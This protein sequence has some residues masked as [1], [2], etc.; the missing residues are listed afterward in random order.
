LVT[1][2][3]LNTYFDDFVDRTDRVA[4]FVAMGLSE[5]T[6]VAIVDAPRRPGERTREVRKR[7]RCAPTAD[8]DTVAPDPPAKAAAAA[9]ASGV[10]HGV[11]EGAAQR[12]VMCGYCGCGTLPECWKPKVDDEFTCDDCYGSNATLGA[13]CVEMLCDSHARVISVAAPAGHPATIEARIVDAIEQWDRLRTVH[14]AK[15][16]LV[17]AGRVQLQID[18]QWATKTPSQR[19]ES[20]T[21]RVGGNMVQLTAARS[22][23]DEM[24][25]GAFHLFDLHKEAIGSMY[26]KLFPGH[27]IGEL[28]FYGIEY[29]HV[30]GP[31]EKQF[32]HNKRVRDGYMQLAVFLA[33]APQATV[34]VRWR[35]GLE[36]A[37]RYVWS[38]R[39]DVLGNDGLTEDAFEAELSLDGDLAAVAAATTRAE[40][41]QVGERLM[42]PHAIRAGHLQAFSVNVNHYGG[43]VEAGKPRTLLV[44]LVNRG[45]DGNTKDLE[46][47]Q[48]HGGL[49]PGHLGLFATTYASRRL[50]EQLGTEFLR[51]QGPDS[52]GVFSASVWRSM[53]NP[54]FQPATARAPLAA[55]RGQS[56]P[57]E[58][59]APL[60][61]STRRSVARIGGSRNAA[62]VE[63]TWVQQHSRAMVH[64]SSLSNPALAAV[65]IDKGLRYS[66]E[67]GEEKQ[68]HF[69]GA[70]AAERGKVT[71]G[72]LTIVC[73]DTLERVLIKKGQVVEI[74]RGL[75]CVLKNE[76]ETVMNKTYAVFDKYGEQSMEYD[77]DAEELLADL[78]CDGCNIDVWWESFKVGTGDDARDYCAA[79]LADEKTCPTDA[80]AVA[81]RHVFDVEAATT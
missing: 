35:P 54:K 75:R 8:S 29:V 13:K 47:K 38:L 27:A 41:E 12:L 74:R 48:E 21:K 39:H 43:E 3:Q 28:R 42:Y 16:H 33:D 4:T 60:A 73:E 5:T 6:A 36:D 49:K 50:Q 20:F 7:K 52:W 67:P 40:M 69:T 2:T 24:A 30:T 15:R 78:T 9:A 18:R 10:L 56:T 68:V 72:Q 55:A 57:V 11:A 31:A 79:C 45:Q 64:V 17:M 59:N 26:D 76:G 71:H 44:A 22:L 80:R 65:G 61:A 62:P 77:A 53:M 70:Y 63:Q 1:G 32:V 25:D 23:Y 51:L 37:A 58:P 19:T 14:D 81:K 66:L 34:H 46:A